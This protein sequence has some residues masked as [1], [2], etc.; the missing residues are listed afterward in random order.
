MSVEIWPLRSADYAA[1]QGLWGGYLEFYGTTVPDAVYA[2]T[3]ARLLGDNDRYSSAL[4]AVQGDTIAGLVHYLFHRH[5][6]R[7]E[8]VCYL[9]GLYW[10]APPYWNQPLI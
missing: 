3:F 4:V 2:S 7:I 8:N 1:W 9:Q 10:L 6:W 5:C